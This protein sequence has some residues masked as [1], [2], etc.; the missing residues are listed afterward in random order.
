MLLKLLLINKILKH[1]L[2]FNRG[3]ANFDQEDMIGGI[4][5]DLETVGYEFLLNHLNISP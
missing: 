2:S 1:S 4:S 3:E 5:L